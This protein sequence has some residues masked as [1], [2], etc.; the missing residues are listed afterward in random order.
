M[1]CSITSLTIILSVTWGIKRLS[2]LFVPPTWRRNGDYY[3]EGTRYLVSEPYGF[4][5]AD[6]FLI[7]FPGIAIANLPDGFTNWLN[8]FLNV[9]TTEI[10]PYYG[11]YNVGGEKGFVSYQ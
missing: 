1:L 2:L 6:E 11:I 7:Y 4:D 3:E 8:A 9:Q 10:F 5:H